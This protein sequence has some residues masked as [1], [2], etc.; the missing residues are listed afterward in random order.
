M[1]ETSTVADMIEAKAPKLTLEATYK[2]AIPVATAV[3]IA[4]GSSAILYNLFV[5]HPRQAVYFNTIDKSNTAT[6][7][8][9]T[10]M[11]SPQDYN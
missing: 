2:S 10:F 6:I 3:S 4:G 11:L 1:I 8:H 7:N 5:L 9:H